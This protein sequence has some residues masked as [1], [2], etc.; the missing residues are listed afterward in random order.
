MNFDFCVFKVLQCTVIQTK[1][2]QDIFVWY[3]FP[4]PEAVLVTIV[5]H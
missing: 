4:V 1:K 5:N 2:K 3:T